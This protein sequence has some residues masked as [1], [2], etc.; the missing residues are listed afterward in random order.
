M[1]GKMFEKC[2]CFVFYIWHI[3]CWGILLKYILVPLNMHLTDKHF[4]TDMLEAL[5]WSFTSDSMR[6]HHNIIYYILQILH[7]LLAT[8]IFRTLYESTHYM[9][10]SLRACEN[11]LLSKKKWRNV[12]MWIHQ[13]KWKKSR[14]A[15][16]DVQKDFDVAFLTSTATSMFLSIPNYLVK[17]I[18]LFLYVFSLI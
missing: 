2:K 10:Y 9:L 15:W 18:F 7:F 1:K 3:L 8:Q 4:K 16:T 12:K 17:N 6:W 14:Y 5:Q 11:T 13:A